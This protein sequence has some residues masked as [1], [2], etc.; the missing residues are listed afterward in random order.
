MVWISFVGW[1]IVTVLF[2]VCGAGGSSLTCVPS[3]PPI[4]VV[5]SGSAIGAAIVFGVSASVIGSAG[6]IALCELLFCVCVLLSTFGLS[7]VLAEE[8]LSLSAVIQDFADLGIMLQRLAG[9]F[10]E[11]RTMEAAGLCGKI[12][13]QITGS[14]LRSSESIEKMIHG[15]DA[16]KELAQNG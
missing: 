4:C 2:S 1:I 8:G 6:L 7:A 9:H 11:N 10:A 15:L 14:K 16:G 5:A 3:V 12:L 13:L